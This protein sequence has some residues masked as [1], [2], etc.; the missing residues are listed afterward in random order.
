MKDNVT[1]I[2]RELKESSRTV[3]RTLTVEEFQ[4]HAEKLVQ[5]ELMLQIPR[6]T[7]DEK[8]FSLS[9]LESLQKMPLKIKENS[10]EKHA[11]EAF[12]NV[13][14]LTRHQKREPKKK[15]KE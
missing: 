11:D 2:R 8:L 5:F 13:E 3:S 9:S 10:E 7:S 12:D 15:D 14:I 4:A 6:G 1:P